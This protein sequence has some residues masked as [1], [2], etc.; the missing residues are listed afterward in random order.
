MDSSGNLYFADSS[1][2]RV[3][4]VTAAT[5]IINTVVGTGTSGFSGDYGAATSAK[6]ALSNQNGTVGIDSFG[7]LY[8]PDGSN[9]RIRKIVAAT[10]TICTIAGN[11]TNSFSGDGGPLSKATFFWPTFLAISPYR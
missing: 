8:I 7:N 2:A 11:G 1:N 9:Y 6:V 4:K 5:G 10:G 3:R